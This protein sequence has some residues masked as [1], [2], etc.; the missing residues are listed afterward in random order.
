V[1]IPSSKG[2]TLLAVQYACT[3]YDPDIL[4]QE[5]ACQKIV[6][7]PK[8]FLKTV[9]AGVVSEAKKEGITEITPEF[10]DKVRSKR[11]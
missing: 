1:P 7:V 9:I 10:M 2:T 5:E 3:H 8:I 6:Q 11:R 4:W